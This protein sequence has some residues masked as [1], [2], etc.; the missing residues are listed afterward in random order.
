MET[1]SAAGQTMPVNDIEMYYEIRGEGEPLLLLHGGTG[2]GANW[3]LIFK[4]PP[5]G[6]RLVIPDLRGHGR[7]TNPSMKFTF[8]QSAL[9]VFALLDG[10]GIKRFKAIGMSLGA[11]TLLHVATQQPD[12]VEAM[13]L[14]SATPYFPEQARAA[15]SEI[16]PDNQT[17][18]EWQRM[19]QW[20]KHGDEQIR[21]LWSM[22]N[23]FKD[24]YDDMN[25]TPPYLSTIT[26]RTLIVHGDRDPLYPVSL[27]M[28][29]YAA[30]PRSYLWV[31]PNGGHGPIF[32]EYT[33][34][35]EPTG[36]FAGTA[37]AFL[38]GEWWAS[39]SPA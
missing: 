14:V 7:S 16:T 36:R 11:K 10:L 28:E 37:L 38:R 8:R 2:V 6:C 35:G 23:A 20:H 12:R 15:M 21:A 5:E 1:P 27:A 34:S 33:G 17:E 39:N 13:V 22:T 31:I 19:R 29:M 18:E 24:S 32:G 30:I 9:D 3:E 4:S 25:F 26:A